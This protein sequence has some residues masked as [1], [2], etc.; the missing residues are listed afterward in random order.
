M[1]TL[2]SWVDP[3]GGGGGG[4]DRG[5]GPPLLIKSQ[6]YRVSL[7][8]WSGSPVKSQSYQASIQC[9]VCICPPAKRHFNGVL[10][11]GRWWPNF[12]DIWILYSPISLKKT[13]STLAPSDKTFWIRA[14][15]SSQNHHCLHKDI[16]K[17]IVS[18]S[19]P[20]IGFALLIK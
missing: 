14:W 3:E 15:Q 1:C 18:S 11:A 7:Q 20:F 17:K 10:L 13:P 19:G 16:H 6:K 9:W 4:G 12:S 8:Y 5:S 2:Q